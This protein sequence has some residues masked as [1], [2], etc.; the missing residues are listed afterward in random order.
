MT[1]ASDEVSII[2]N[3]T[4]AFT[5][6]SGSATDNIST[7]AGY[8]NSEELRL[9]IPDFPLQLSKVTTPNPTDKLRELASVPTIN[10]HELV[11]VPLDLND[12]EVTDEDI[13]LELI[14]F[15]SVLQEKTTQLPDSLIE[16]LA[17]STEILCDKF[18]H[19]AELEASVDILE[20]SEDSM[21]I[22]YVEL[23][24]ACVNFLNILNIEPTKENI[25][26]L[27]TLI[28]IKN[29]LGVSTNYSVQNTAEQGTHEQKLGTDKFLGK[30]LDFVPDTTASL[31][32]LTIKKVN[33]ALS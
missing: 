21:E 15:Q 31:G 16:V 19:L 9:H 13:A 25:H 29:R 2:L 20:L 7:P 11:F 8:T 1:Q 27:K 10:L 22:A 26:H 24:E 3:Q 30:L 23:E 14:D 12:M 5:S 18:N 32:R 33:L 6:L 28:S 4:E 17:S